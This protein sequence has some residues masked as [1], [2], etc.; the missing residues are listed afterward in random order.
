MEINKCFLTKN[1]CYKV[2]KPMTPKGI[3]VHSTGANN[4][5]LKRY[6]QP[7]DGIL[8][9]NKN[10]NSWNASGIAKCVHAFIGK[11]KNGDVRC[12][13]TLPFNIACWGVGSGKKGSYNYNP[14][15]HIQFEICEDNLTNADYFNKCFNLAAEFCA[16]LCKE[17]NLS[18]DSIVG[19]HEAYLKGYGSNHNDPDNW[20]KKFGKDMNWFRNLVREKMGNT[21]VKDD[22]TTGGY[23]L[24][25]SKALR[26]S[27]TLGLNTVR[28]KKCDAFT[29]Q[30][31]TSSKPGDTAMLTLGGPG[32][33]IREIYKEANGRVWGKW[34]GYWIVLCNQD[35]TP[36]AKRV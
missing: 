24:L 5:N 33:T 22:W 1:D 31:L 18:V 14:T 6:V 32:Y 27:H 20:M 34:N 25:V 9:L 3:V 36:Q 30:Y 15:G 17:F 21:P 19:H 8:G 10:N 29:K 16:Y 7:D 11:D 35:G 12:Y 28:V 2:S 13:Q 4:P 26:T 23:K